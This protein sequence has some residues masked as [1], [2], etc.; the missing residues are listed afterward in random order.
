MA[1]TPTS[2]AKN[3]KSAAKKPA[4]KKPAAKKSTAKKPAVSKPIAKK[5]AAKPAAKKPAAKKP[6][7]KQAPSKKTVPQKA[8]PKKPMPKMAPGAKAAP[9]RAVPG[10]ATSSPKPGSA[11]IQPSP[12]AS[13]RGEAVERRRKPDRATAALRFQRDLLA[14]IVQSSQNPIMAFRTIRDDKGIADFEWLVINAAAGRLLGTGQKKL[15]GKGLRDTLPGRNENALFRHYIDVVETGR[16][17]DYEQRVETGGK[18]AWFRVHAVKLGDGLCVTMSDVTK[19]KMV[20][21]AAIPKSPEPPPF[22]SAN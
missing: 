15:I 18:R 7:A 11:A 4:G 13:A 16:P 3:S 14:N 22:G 10:G 2:P 6:A 19:Y 1:R 12:I 20:T 9:R 17:F 21:P 8:T 5:A